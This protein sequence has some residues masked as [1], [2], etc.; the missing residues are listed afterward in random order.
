M[1]SVQDVLQDPPNQLYKEQ[2]V[3]INLQDQL[4][5]FLCK[6]MHDTVYVHV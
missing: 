2:H 6:Y 3:Y 4:C 1:A 5:L